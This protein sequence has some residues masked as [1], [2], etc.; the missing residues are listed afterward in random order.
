[1]VE[2]G[3]RNLWKPLEREICAVIDVEERN[4]AFD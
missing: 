2:N 3:Y 1:V 4:P